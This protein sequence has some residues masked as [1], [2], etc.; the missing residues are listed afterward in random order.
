MHMYPTMCIAFQQYRQEI[1][2]K[3]LWVKLWSENN[4]NSV[5]LKQK[6]KTVGAIDTLLDMG[7]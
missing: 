7:I 2:D 3:N 6:Q 4:I 5:I 1:E